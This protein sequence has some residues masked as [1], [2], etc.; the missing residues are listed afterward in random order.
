MADPQGSGVQDPY[1]PRK[2]PASNVVGAQPT[3]EE[4]ELAKQIDKLFEKYAKHRRRYDTNWVQFYKY[5]RGQQFPLGKRL[6]YKHREVINMVFQTVQSQTSTILDVRPTISFS[7]REPNDVEVAE[8]LNEVFESDWQRNNWMDEVSAV[9]YD[10][11]IYGV[12]NSYVGYDKNISGGRAGICFSAKDPFDYYPDPAATDVNK[13]CEGFIEARSEDID[14]VRKEWAQSKYVSLLK[15]D[16]QDLSRSKRQAQLLVRTKN[17]DL[18]LPA[19]NV[20]Y[21]ISPE[22]EDK[23]KVLVITAY[24]KPSD[25]EEIEKDDEGGDKLYITR[26]KYPKGRKVV[27]INNYIMSD[28]ELDYDDLEF[29]FERL[30]NY[31]LPREYFGQSEVEQVIGPQNVFNKLVN[32]A[33]DVLVLMGNPVWKVPVDSKVNTRKLINQPG[34]IIEY[35]GERGPER[36]PG[37]EL[38]PYVF[39]LI[40]RME[41][42][43]NDTAGTQDVTRGVNPTGVTAN[44]AIENLL[45]QASKRTKQKMRNLDSYLSQVGKHWVSRCFQYYT[46]PEIYRLT[47]KDGVSKYFKFHVEPYQAMQTNEDGSQSPMLGVDG[48]PVMKKRAVIRGFLDHPAGGMVPSEEEKKYEIEG[49]MDVVV[50]TVSGLASTKSDTERLVMQLRQMEIIDDEE[51]LKRLDYPNYKEV[52]QRVAQEKASAAQSQPAQGGNK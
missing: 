48:S 52:L 36:E 51:V 28:T 5:Y 13:N 20:S 23:D 8:I 18:D 7:P 14:K 38:Q 19:T 11:H 26:R 34:L 30:V 39:Q 47:N 49:E 45:E 15:P 6:S 33:L 44:S 40:D 37:V 25:V 43:F 32:F 31:I 9:L 4:K 1:A 46:V 29:P 41:K 2:L 16:L 35:A 42:W 12:G 10:A 3:P 24:L 21:G 17:T 22:D 27:K 50:N